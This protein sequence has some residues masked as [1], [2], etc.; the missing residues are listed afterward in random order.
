MKTKAALLPLL[1]MFI[2]LSSYAQSR[3]L[4]LGNV[5][6]DHNWEKHSG[7]ASVSYQGKHGFINKAGTVVIPLQ[8]SLAY[9]FLNGM[10]RVRE[11]GS[12]TYGYINAKGILVIPFMYGQGTHFSECGLAGVRKNDKWGYID[13]EN[14]IIV[15]FE[16]SAAMPFFEGKA[17]V[18]KGIDRWMIDCDGKKIE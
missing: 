12:Y 3:E 10:A 14:N 7:L 18:F 8:Y 17:E 13:K 2:S 6:K 16:Y 4:L 15:P 1:L 9:P 5:D 11:G